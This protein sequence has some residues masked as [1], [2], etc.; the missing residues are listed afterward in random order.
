MSKSYTYTLNEKT[1]E[2][3]CDIG[4][5][6]TKTIIENGTGIDVKKYATVDVA[7]PSPESYTGSYN[8]TENGTIY[9]DG[10]VATDDI[11]VNVSSGPSL[12]VDSVYYVDHDSEISKLSNVSNSGIY[13]Y[14]G[15]GT[16]T[17]KDLQSG[18]YYYDGDGYFTEKDVTSGS[19]YYYSSDDF[20]LVDID[21]GQGAFYIY[22]GNGEFSKLKIPEVGQLVVWTSNTCGTEYDVI[23]LPQSG[24]T[25]T[26]EIEGVTYSLKVVE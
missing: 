13:Y 15:S 11:V 1:L 3:L 22:N 8:I 14:D 26:F 18:L 21:S 17:E 10:K 24:Q 4:T 20:E 6:G 16:F 19:L 2:K 12:D 23:D 5:Q 25:E 7:V 9:I